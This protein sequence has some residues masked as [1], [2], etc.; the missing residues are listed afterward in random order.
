MTAAVYAVQFIADKAKCFLGRPGEVHLQLLKQTK[1]LEAFE[2]APQDFVMGR[3]RRYSDGQVLIDVCSDLWRGKLGDGSPLA[4]FSPAMR[5]AFEYCIVGA[6]S[7]PVFVID[8][9]FEH[10][11]PSI[12]E[13]RFRQILKDS[14]TGFYL[15][16]TSGPSQVPT[17]KGHQ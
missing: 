3:Y 7:S 1:I 5:K 6:L 8:R 4:R 11:A 10:R 17:T 14:E 15:I 16:E 2:S 12:N 13:R 9:G